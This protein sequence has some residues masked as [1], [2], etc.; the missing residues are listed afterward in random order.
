MRYEFLRPWITD[1]RIH[2][3]R[4]GCEF[5]HEKQV[6]VLYE[7]VTALTP[8]HGYKGK[9]KQAIKVLKD[10]LIDMY[11]SREQ[12]SLQEFVKDWRSNKPTE[13]RQ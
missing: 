7:V 1:E 4:D 9:Q 11:W 13:I 6:E 10:L 12:V 8:P 5:I 3:E 2:K